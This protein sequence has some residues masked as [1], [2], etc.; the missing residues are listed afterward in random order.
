MS[1]KRDGSG[2]EVGYGKP[3]RHS[4]FPP[5][6]SGF[7]GRRKKPLEAHAE[8]VARVRDEILVVGG[9]QI[10]KFE[11][12]I[13]QTVN[14]TIKS[15]K[16]RDLKIMMEILDK[17]GALPEPDRLAEAKAGAEKTRKKI[18][19]Y[20]D[21]TF[22]RDPIDRPLLEAEQDAEAKLIMGCSEC[23]PQLRR[24]W[25]TQ[26]YKELAERYGRS[27]LQVMVQEWFG[28]NSQG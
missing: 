10:S 8:I 5:G 13:Q 18:N 6:V 24:R 16:P 3:P 26:S 22:N 17:Y 19:D 1:G 28:R 23:A 27:S 14:Q 9:K 4:Q 21:R 25:A 12:A 7:K 11:L 2:Y 15:G 20:L